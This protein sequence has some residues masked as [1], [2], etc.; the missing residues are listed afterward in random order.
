MSR[1]FV[2]FGAYG[3]IGDFDAEGMTE[4]QIHE[5]IDLIVTEF[6]SGEVG[7]IFVENE[8]DY[9]EHE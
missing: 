9:W 2:E 6:V 4:D 8:K 1:C 5:E 7:W 3:A